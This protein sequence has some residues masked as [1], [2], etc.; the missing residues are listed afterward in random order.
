MVPPQISVQLFGRFNVYLC[1]ESFPEAT[2][3]LVWAR[4]QEVVYVDDQEESCLLEEDARGM[5]WD[6]LASELYNAFLEVPFPMS[7]RFR[8]AV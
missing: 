4:E 5:S 8:V 2:M 6:G 3:L 7:S 1:A